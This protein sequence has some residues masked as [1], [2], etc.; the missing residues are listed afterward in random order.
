[1]YRGQRLYID[2]LNK[3]KETVGR[4]ISLSPFFSTSADQAVAQLF[5][6]PNAANTE[7]AGIF[8]T[9]IVDPNNIHAVYADIQHLSRY[10]TENEYLFS[11]R[12]LFRI[13]QIELH[14]NLWYIDMT[15]VDEDDQEFCLA[16]NP[17]KTVIGEQSFFSGRDQPL[18]TRYLTFENGPFIAF[19]LLVDLM[20][21]LDQTDFARQEMIEMCQKNYQ[22]SPSDLK[23]IDEFERTYRS[24]DAIKWYT[25]GSFLHR[26]INNSLRFE[27]IDTLF[28]LRY[29]IY[30]LHNQLA[31]LQIQYIETLS[32]DQSVLTLY[33]GQRMTIIE[34][35]KLQKNVDTL[36]SMNS[37]L[38]TTTN[39]EAAIFFAGD[40][41][42]DNPE[43]EVSVLYQ[44]TVDTRLP[45]SIPFAK[46]DYLSV[47]ENEDEVLFSMAS[48]F[49]IDQVEQYGNLWVVDLTLI[50]KEDEV[51][52]S[53][54]AHLND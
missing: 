12:S 41:S 21:R 8:Y 14:D 51:W 31:Q 17:W 25:S 3:L 28:K 33:R 9:I 19:Q 7:K 11:L 47:Y 29:Y 50:N 13:D 4:L 5:T 34:L 6:E 30:D 49:R 45:H 48:V 27:D 53:L 2:R 15:V 24:Q 22:N 46:I 16:I 35:K 26:L 52:N 38:S 36:I 54:T 37:F 43:T 20:L 10:Q 40:G 42:L 44:I 39:A 32:A 18:F 1:M 23:K